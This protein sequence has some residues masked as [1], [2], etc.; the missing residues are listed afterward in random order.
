MQHAKAQLHYWKTRYIVCIQIPKMQN[1]FSLLSLFAKS[2][3]LAQGVRIN[4]VLN[5]LREKKNDIIFYSQ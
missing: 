1:I 4:I 2:Y 3:G 5:K